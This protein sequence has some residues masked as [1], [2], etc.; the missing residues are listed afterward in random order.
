MKTKYLFLVPI[1]LAMLIGMAGA[2]TQYDGALSITNLSVSPSPVMAGGYVNISFQLYNSYDGWLYSTNLQPS[3]SYPL[4]NASPLSGKVIGIINPGQNSTK[5]YNYS[6]HIPSTTPAGT[7]TVTFTAT[8]FVLAG[9]G[10]VIATSQL[11]I[12][13]YVQNKPEIKIVPE[14]SQSAALYTGHNQTITLLVENIGYGTARNVTVDVSGGQGLNILSP[15]TTFFISNL[16][17]GSSASE[18]I[19]VGA[20]SLNSTYIIANVNYDSSK[21]E[22]S[23]SSTQ[24][25][26]LSVAPAAQFS[27]NSTGGGAGVG[28]ADVPV[29]FKVTNTGTSDASEVQF[30]LETTYPITPVSSTAYINNLAPGETANLTF[31]VD[32][33]TAGVPGQYPVTLYEQWKQPNGAENQQFTGSNNYF[34]PVVT[35]GLGISGII[36]GIIAVVV[37]I[38]AGVFVYRRRM[39]KK[40]DN[41]KAKK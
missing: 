23:F 1:A 20:Q 12:T 7:Y 5:Y 30:T 13:F 39:A 40:P 8:Y 38:G 15:V 4:L 36:E 41:H 2:Q 32:V 14:S 18:P 31:L 28:A 35:P 29:N 37:V 34:V 22:Q 33:D 17:P 19:L 11:P 3:A 25:I 9:T 24:R 6:I 21:F 16:T 26:N 10:T 27:I